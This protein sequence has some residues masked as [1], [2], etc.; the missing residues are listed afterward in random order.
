MTLR[1]ALAL[2]ARASETLVSRQLDCL[3]LSGTPVLRCLRLAAAKASAERPW[4]T[5]KVAKG[6]CF[7][8]LSSLGALLLP[9]MFR[10]F[11]KKKYII[12]FSI[13]YCIF[14]VL[15]PPKT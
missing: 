13:T 11:V 8:A 2:E 5:A 10:V 6:W 9:S 3:V 7:S 15:C 4:L 1:L 14:N 12:R